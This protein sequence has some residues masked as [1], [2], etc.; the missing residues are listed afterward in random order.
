MKNRAIEQ[1]SIL[2]NR[3]IEHSEQMSITINRAFRA[4]EQHPLLPANGEGAG[5]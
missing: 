5:K 1:S 4:F 3:A 2:S